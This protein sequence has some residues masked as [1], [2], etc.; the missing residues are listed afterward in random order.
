MVPLL[1]PAAVHPPRRR[2]R[3]PGSDAWHGGVFGSGCGTHLSQNTAS[4]H[5]PYLGE[6]MF[7]RE[8]CV[9]ERIAIKQIET[10]DGSCANSYSLTTVV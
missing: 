9:K 7:A 8:K 4:E 10:S 1:P 2:Q 3:H 6:T 5:V